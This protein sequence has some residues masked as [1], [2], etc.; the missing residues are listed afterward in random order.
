MTYGFLPFAILP[1]FVSIDRLDPALVPA[2]RDLYASGRGGVPARDP[3][4]DDAR[5]R[6]RRAPDLHPGHRRLRHAGPARRRRRRRP[7]PRSSRS[8]SSRAATGRTGRRSGSS[9][10]SSPWAGRSSRCGRC[11]GRS[12]AVSEPAMTGSATLAV[13]VRAIVYVFLF[14]PI[15]VLIIF[16]FNDSRREL[17]R[18]GASRSTGI[19]RLRQRGPARRA[20]RHPPGRRRRGRRVDRARDAAGARRWRGAG[21]AARGATETLLLVPMVTP[22]IVMGLSLLIFFFQLF[23]GRRRRSGSCR[24]PT[25]RS[26]SSYVAIVVRARAAGDGPAARGGRPRPRGVGA[27]RVPLRD[28]AAH[29][30]G[31]H[32]RGAA[33]L[34][35]VV[36]RL[37]RDDVQRRRRLVDAAAVHLR[38]GQVRGDAGDQRD[39]DDHRGRHGRASSWPPGG[40]APAATRRRRATLA[41]DETGAGRLAGDQPTGTSPQ[42][43]T[44]DAHRVEHRGLGRERPVGRRRRRR[45][46]R[47]GCGWPCAGPSSGRGSRR[48]GRRA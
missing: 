20:V 24:S 1:L 14:A 28:A 8:C 45:R 5:D 10:W 17:R 35:P 13:G 47:P 11:A 7:S 25:S 39:L 9:S 40:S 37:R 4:A 38:Q 26:A 48:R 34:R 19:R 12:S 31:H 32:Q 2:A 23:D 6:R 44:R 30:P 18:G 16:S 15:V 21:S 29:L 33:R 43:W 42:R 27:G 41:A 36:R 3:A 22:E 46:R